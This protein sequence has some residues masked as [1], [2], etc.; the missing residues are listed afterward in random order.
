MEEK[1]KKEESY[2]N[3]DELLNEEELEKVKNEI[4]PIKI[5]QSLR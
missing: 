5:V 2:D 4:K 3:E 1:K